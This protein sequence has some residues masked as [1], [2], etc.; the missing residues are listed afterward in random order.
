[1]RAPE[2]PMIGG[3]VLGEQPG[4]SWL[5]LLVLLLRFAKLEVSKIHVI[6][7]CP[8]W[9]LASLVWEYPGPGWEVA[10]QDCDALRQSTPVDQILRHTSTYFDVPIVRHCSYHVGAYA[11]PLHR[12][13][14]MLESKHIP[15]L[16]TASKPCF[17]LFASIW[18]CA[19]CARLQPTFTLWLGQRL[20]FCDNSKHLLSWKC[21][22]TTHY[23]QANQK[24]LLPLP[25]FL[26]VLWVFRFQ[27]QCQ[28][29][30]LVGE[31]K[32]LQGF[33]QLEVKPKQKESPRNHPAKPMPNQ[34]Q[35]NGLLGFCSFPVV[36]Q[37]FWNGSRTIVE[38]KLQ[39]QGKLM[40]PFC[41]LRY[42]KE[43]V[44]IRLIETCSCM[45]GR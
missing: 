43:R 6:S 13:S 17:I 16:H 25:W 20:E 32:M 23:F 30:A 9:S 4:W 39:L 24:I 3:Q 11:A 34:C 8:S 38:G 27:T 37:W 12:L 40:K 33:R 41:F 35:A 19:T 5:I 21:N 18:D 10:N 1:M 26:W 45:L 44:E 31:A 29:K 2:L 42:R 7:T 36:F 22:G 14:N 28:G 15:A